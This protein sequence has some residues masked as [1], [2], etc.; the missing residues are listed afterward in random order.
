M[1]KRAWTNWIFQAEY[2]VECQVRQH[3]C[4]KQKLGDVSEI[5]DVFVGFQESCMGGACCR[6]DKDNQLHRINAIRIAF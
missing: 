3:S 5:K 6:R 4:G 2:A 1:Y